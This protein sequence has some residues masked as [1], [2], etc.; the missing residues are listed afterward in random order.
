MRGWRRF[1]GLSVS[2]RLLVCEAALLLTL[3]GVG[4]RVLPRSVLHGW[5]RRFHGQPRPLHDGPHL[6]EVSS[7]VSFDRLSWAVTAAAR[8]L[9]GTTCLVQALVVHTMLRCRGEEPQLRFGV[10]ARDPDQDR[11]GAHAW[12][13]CGGVVVIGALDDLGHYRVLSAPTSRTG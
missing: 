7:R 10:K 4:L 2:D 11:L 3:V 13:E 12:V 8:R 6:Q 1:T 9:R 5:L